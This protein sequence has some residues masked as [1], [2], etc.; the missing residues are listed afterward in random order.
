MAS[1][2]LPFLLLVLSA[3]LIST[4][5]GPASANPNQ[6]QDMPPEKINKVK[7]GFKA[8]SQFVL[9]KI[10]T[11]TSIACPFLELIP[12]CGPALSFI[13]K[14]VGLGVS[15]TNK[16]QGMIA[17]M[18]ELVNLNTKLDQYHVEHKWNSWASGA[19]HKPEMDIE[20]AWSKYTTLLKSLRQ[21]KNVNEMQR[22][23][24]EFKG[25]YMSFEPATN[26]LHKL[27]ITKGVTFINPLGDLLAEKVNC[28]EK[29]IREYSVL[30]NKLIYKGNTMNYFY[31]KL[32]DIASEPVIDLGAQIHYESMSAMFQV[33]MKCINSSMEYVKKDVTGLIDVKIKHTELAKKVWSSLVQVSASPED[34]SDQNPYIFRGECQRFPGVKGGKFVVLIKSDEEIMTVD[35]CFN[36]DCGG[37]GRGSCVRVPDIFLAVCHCNTNYYGQNCM[38]D[39]GVILRAFEQFR[40]KSCVDF[41]PRAAEE[42]YISV[43]SHEGCWS[44]IGRSSPGGQTL[45]IGNGCGIKGIVEHEFLHALGFYHEQSRYDRD[46]YVTINYENIKKGYESYFNKRS[47]NSST[48]QET[49]YDYYSVMHFD[50]NAF[51]NGNGSTIITKQPKFQ[52]VIGQLME[53]SEYDVIEL[54]KLYKCNSSVSFLDHCSFDNESL[55][56]MSICSAAD[57]GWQRV[58]SVNG[59]N[60]TDHT[61]LGKDVNGTSF[62]MHFSTEGR[63]EGD[64]A[65]METKTMT[66]TRDC[67]VQ[68]LQFYYYH[69]GNESDQLNIWI[70]EQ[71]NEADSRGTLRLMDQIIEPPGNYWKLHHVPLNANKSFQVV[72][73]ARKGAGNSSG[74]FS[75]D[76]INISET[77]CP[78]TWQIR[79]I[80]KILNNYN[81]QVMWSP[82]YYSSEGYR[83]VAQLELSSDQLLIQVFSVAGA[84]DDQLQWPC[85][86][87]QITVQILDQNPHIQRRMSFEQSITTDP[88]LLVYDDLYHW[89]NP[90]KG[91]WILNTG[92]ETV[93][94]SGSASFV[95]LAKEDLTKREFIKGGDLIFLFTMQDISAL[96]QNDSLPC[97]KVTLKSF[98][99]SSNASALQEPC[100]SRVVPTPETTSTAT[101]TPTKPT[102]ESTEGFMSDE[103]L[104]STDNAFM[105]FSSA[106]LGFGSSSC[107]TCGVNDRGIILRAFEQF[108][109]KSCVDFKP[110]AAEEF[111]ISVESHEGCWSYIGRSSLGGQTLSIGNGCGIK[112]IVEHEFLHALG[113]YHEHS[114]YD[115]DDYVTINYENIKKGYESY[116]SKHSESSSTTQETPYDYYSVMHFDKNAFSNGNGSTIIINQSKFQDV[117]GQL[118]EMSEYDVIELNKL[119]K[120]N[121]SVSFLDHC[122]FDDESLCQMSVCSAA[123]YGWQRVK[124][125]SGINVTDHTYL[126]REANGT[127]FFMHF[128]TEGRIEGDAARMET[129]TMTPTRDYKVQCLQFYYYH[130]GNESDQLNIWIR[131]HQNEAD[132]RGAL[133]LMDQIIEPPG[134]YW[135]LHH[136]PLNA[137]KSFQV[138]IE[139]RKGAGNSSGGFSLD[140]INISE[141]QC[142]I[143]WQIRDFEKILNSEQWIWSPFYYSSDGYRFVALLHV[144]NDQLEIYVG[145]VV[146]AYDK[147]LQWPCPWRQITVQILDQNPHIQKRISFEQS[148]TTDPNLLN[149]GQ[150]FKQSD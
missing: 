138:V 50:K 17:L 104:N 30:I 91:P 70:R 42:F 56:Q 44:Y 21:A 72:F 94:H 11:I 4:A 127:S 77:E 80:E 117:I 55:C 40:L 9:N 125:V 130:S 51:S 93:L 66:P 25:T 113:F 68:C 14:M 35:P 97:P 8:T 83:F 116:F 124:T 140:D 53:M 129:K 3:L 75:L 69:S 62:F 46:D 106:E 144:S 10:T 64:T 78:L 102:A 134:N 33:H 52:D 99:I 31:Y 48:T 39:R 101:T 63:M 34:R 137:N 145:T 110:R 6:Q 123:D 84:Y 82:F 32:K 47:E 141:T 89:D 112:G 36:L 150:I 111:Y 131:E 90:Q 54:N 16:N 149:S 81:S 7:E 146:G 119:Y 109:L 121:S 147:Q 105:C 22:H 132:S 108:R 79:D 1:A 38:N 118:M 98:N 95:L 15:L 26:K 59:T 88:K 73:E 60:V 13:V 92:R 136:V 43:E 5:F 86:W 41:K 135:K 128:S 27:L 18:D 139:A 49:P 71:Q 120:C 115:R 45:S 148:I 37:P 76:D 65:R 103:I 122:S 100:A 58:K 61:Y 126:G 107:I 24:E 87:R 74:G 23:Q 143:T 67:K 57:Y 29:S 96:I 19:Y 85:P 142:P 12:V 114:R 2:G 133:R 20:V 28:H